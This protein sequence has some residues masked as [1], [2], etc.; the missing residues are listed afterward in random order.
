MINPQILVIVTLFI[1]GSL[2]TG[3]IYTFALSG[4]GTGTVGN[5]HPALQMEYSFEGIFAAIIYVYKTLADWVRKP[6]REPAISYTLPGYNA[7]KV[8]VD[9]VIKIVFTVTMKSST[10][11]DTNITLA[12][13]LGG[14]NIA[15]TIALIP[16]GMAATITPTSS[17]SNGTSYTVT[18]TT[19]VQASNDVPI[20]TQYQFS[21]IT[22][23]E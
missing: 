11:N 16:S 15:T 4:S 12:P 19:N 2:T 7:V 23:A 6:A 5:D 9:Q 22:V 18:V 3:T 1:G 10:I 21:F 8:P 20:A 13:T 14:P 17:L